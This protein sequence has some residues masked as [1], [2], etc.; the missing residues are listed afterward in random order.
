[1]FKYRKRLFI[2]LLMGLI[3][4]SSFAEAII[5]NAPGSYVSISKLSSTSVRISSKDNSDNED[6]FYALLYDYKTSAL[7]Q[8]KEI[9]NSNNGYVYAD[10]TGLVC[11]KL[12]ST[13]VLAFNE[14]GN[15]SLSKTRHFNIH[16]TF[17][18]PCSVYTPP[19]GSPATPGP[20]IG[21]TDIDKTSVQVNFLDN[22][23]N[24]DGFLL[25][26]ESG[27]INITVPKNNKTAPSQTSV[28]LRGLRCN[29][30]YT[31]RTLAF[32]NN[33]NS[34]MSNERVFNI[35]STFGFTCDDTPEEPDT[36][37]PVIALLGDT[38]V[39][40]NIGDTYTDAGATATDNKDGNMTSKIKVIGLPINTSAEGNY[41]ITYSVSDKAGN[42][43]DVVTRRVI[44]NSIPDT[45]KPVITLLGDKTV[46]LT[47]GDTYTDAGATAT[48][49]KDG[50]ITSKIKVTG[51][52][53]NT[54][55]EGNYTVT[56]LVSDSSGN[57]ADAVTRAIR[58]N[59]APDTTKPV[60]TLLGNTSVT[61][62]VGDTYTDAG[63][64]AMDDVD[65]NITANIQVTGL[66]I[67]TSSE[68]NYTITY[69]VADLA[70][71]VAD[72][73]TRKINVIANTPALLTKNVPLVPANCQGHITKS[74]LDINGN[75]LL[76]EDEITSS[77]EHYD[78][79]TPITREDLI[80]KIGNGDDVTQVNTCKITDMSHLFD[81]SEWYS[82]Y[83]EA[84]KEIVKN[85][86][87]DISGWNTGS[88]TTMWWMFYGA[89]LFNQSLDSWDVSSVT[90]MRGMFAYAKSFNQPL[91]SWNVS[92]VID[93]LEMFYNSTIFNQPL[94]GWDVSSVILMNGMFME[95]RAFN[96]PLDSWDV[97]H[98]TRMNNMFEG[99]K[100]FNQPLNS[101]NVSNVTFY[102]YSMFDGAVSFN[103]PLN[104]WDVSNATNMQYMF[105]DT[106][107]FNQDISNWN[108][109]N[110]SDHDNFAE[111]SALENTHNPF[112]E[113]VADTTKPIITLLGDENVTL[114]I[115]DT[116]TDAG[117]RATD[118]VDGNITSN[119]LVTGLPI[120]TS[121]EGNYTVSYNIS[122][123]AGNLADTVTRNVNVV[124]A[125]KHNYK[126]TLKT[127]EK[128]AG[129][130]IHLKFTNDTA[131]ESDV[132][133]NN[134]F[135]GTTGRNVMNLGPDINST[136][137][138]IKFGGF[139]FG[140]QDGIVGNFDVMT[141]KSADSQSLITVSYKS[142]IDK[143]ADEIACDIEVVSN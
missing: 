17:S 103:Q 119:I 100:A 57:I 121:L 66:P 41:T 20:Y 2:S 50:N 96:Q 47:V 64:T 105:H 136:T 131:I 97:S 137:K 14:D 43:A 3:F 61:L 126:I 104:N 123:S 71:N 89:E 12:Y 110:V 143:N 4:F 111:N 98:V 10:F 73:I 107:S 112:Y 117:A 46:T 106:T 72:T 99:A 21:V 51:L 24:E 83:S 113:E 67:N 16:S 124:V 28:T 27:D 86:N 116:Y 120:D 40:L 32:N 85:F 9:S 26:D 130:E 5:P 31:L 36:S 95:A 115:G 13:N 25:F 62:T 8:K 81:V 109:S 127:T 74:G 129:Y 102:M 6:G 35:H 94:N 22:A 48:D 19:I 58:V 65:G 77:E 82:L 114:T 23:N 59:L 90:T 139:T 140:S 1:M 125:P 60:I 29:K 108:V 141:L 52:P 18:T 142:C 138:E 78:N 42:V 122:D 11:D 93:M 15:S 75:G 88:V 7:V 128:I 135:L 53:I 92:N 76:D 84:Q 79:G 55:S 87:Q 80:T 45:T 91:N 33:G 133:V 34:S 49:N 44:V 132:V 70:G 63:A 54:S 37:K 56:Y 68:G 118:D 69:S 101:W 39:T 38:T 134:S 30:T